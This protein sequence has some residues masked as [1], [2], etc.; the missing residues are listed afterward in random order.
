MT[1]KTVLGLDCVELLNE[2]LSLLIP[3][4][5]GPR[6]LSLSIDG[7][8]NLLAEL[9]TFALDCPGVGTLPLWGGHRLWHAPEV[10]ERT[11]YP[12]DKPVVIEVVDGGLAVTQSADSSHIEKTVTVT[13]PDQ[14]ATVVIDH[15]LTNRG[16]WSVTCAPWAITQMRPG[17]TAILPQNGELV[18]PGGFQA[19]RQLALWPYAAID[20]ELVTWGDRFIF[21]RS[22]IKD[23]SAWKVGYP[24]RNGWLGY[25]VDGTLFV[26]SAEYTP[27]AWYY[28]GQSSSECYCNKSFLE[29]E[30]LGPCS[31]I[32]PGASITHR[33]TWRVFNNIA[34]EPDE[35]A[36]AELVSSL[37]LG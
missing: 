28:D 9:P 6:I 24:N 17:G 32:E 27:N 37:G 23:E 7:G 5:V 11:Y 22:E 4:A 10:A 34:F 35:D 30:T 15:T 3:E 25:W 36:V 31:N 18:D 29:L 19:N 1:A 14:S 13:L 26:K 33:E 20:S 21:Y 2:R 12:D 16:L 8:D